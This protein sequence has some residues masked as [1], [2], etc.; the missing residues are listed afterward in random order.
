MKFI[1]YLSSVLT[2]L[3][4]LAN[5]PKATSFGNLGGQSELFSYTKS[6]QVNIQLI[7]VAT[8]SVFLLLTIILSS[9]LFT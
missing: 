9:H 6:T 7:T 1:W 2:I 8:S 3:L 4:I 5:S